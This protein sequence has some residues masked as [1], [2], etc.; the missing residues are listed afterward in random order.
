MAPRTKQ[1]GRGAVSRAE[2][3][4]ERTLA[5]SIALHGLPEPERE[6]MFHPTRK[7]RIDF[8]WPA[9]MLAVEIEGGAFSGPGH[10]SVGVFLKNIEKYNALT[11]LGWRLLRFHGDQVKSG[12]AV[13]IIKQALGVEV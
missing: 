4:L 5:Q 9:V 12:E 3:D 8:S 6:L 1:E 13:A 10:R 7:W 11:L 2:S